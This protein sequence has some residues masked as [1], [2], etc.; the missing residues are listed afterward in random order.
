M[1]YILMILI[2]L[3]LVFLSL[4]M[5]VSLGWVSALFLALVALLAGGLAFKQLVR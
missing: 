1:F 3:Y 5:F 2:A 4:Q